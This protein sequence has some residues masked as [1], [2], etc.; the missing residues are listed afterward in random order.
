[1]LT[2]LAG[3]IFCNP[4][5]PEGYMA[6][7]CYKNGSLTREDVRDRVAGKSWAQFNTLL[8]ATKPGNDGNIGFFFK[9]TEITPQGYACPRSTKTELTDCTVLKAFIAST[10]SSAHS[11]PSLPRS[12]FVPWWRASS[13]RCGCTPPMSV[14]QS[15]PHYWQQAARRAIS[16]S[17]RY[18]INLTSLLTLIK[19]AA[20]VFGVPVFTAPTANSAALGAAMRALH[21]LKC[22]AGFVPMET[23]FA[24]L[25]PFTKIADPH[26][27]AHRIYTEML[28]IYAQLEKRVL[29]AAAATHA[30]TASSVSLPSSITSSPSSSAL[31]VVRPDVTAE[32]IG[33]R[34][35]QRAQEQ[36][37]TWLDVTYEVIA[38]TVMNRA[39]E[40]LFTCKLRFEDLVAQVCLVGCSFDGE[41]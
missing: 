22:Q 34:A 2:K 21:G 3:H 5:D 15:S 37:R 38:K 8:A 24:S 17:H 14:S 10:Q 39:A 29:G 31:R 41:C 16:I 23:L 20:D 33:M 35:T 25:P 18:A 6:L 30:A 19:I 4:A 9:E 11:L 36:M 40:G 13:F 32:S 12:K 27:E 28:P 1:M 26:P 7:L